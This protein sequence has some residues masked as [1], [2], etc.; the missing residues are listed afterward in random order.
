M[1]VNVYASNSGADTRY[2]ELLSTGDL[3]DALIRLF[4][5]VSLLLGSKVGKKG[6]DILYFMSIDSN[7][8]SLCF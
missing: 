8:A 4:M 3:A 6:I 1:S 2:I 7:V 5:T